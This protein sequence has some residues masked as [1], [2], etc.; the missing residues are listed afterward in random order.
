MPI[1]IN[2]GKIQLR[3]SD[4]YHDL[5]AIQGSPGY[6]VQEGGTAGQVLKKAS[7][8]DYD[9]E[10][11][12]E[13]MP[14]KVSDLDNDTGFITGMEI[15]SY[16][17]STYADF[18]AAYTAKKVV[19]CRASS[20]AN[21]ASG[22]QTRL[23][24]MAYVNDADNPTEVEFQYYRSV[25]AHTASQQGDQ[26]FVYK[27]TKTA[28]WTVT[29][30]EASSKIV[31]GTNM[32]SSYSNGVI[33]LNADTPTK[34]MVVTVTRSGHALS[35]DKTFSEIY[36]AYQNGRQIIA[37]LGSDPEIYTLLSVSSSLI[38]FS[39][40]GVNY[41]TTTGVAQ[42]TIRITSSNSVSML[43]GQ[44]LPPP[45]ISNDN[46]IIT[47]ELDETVNPPRYFVSSSDVSDVSQVTT[48]YNEKTLVTLNYLKDYF[49][50]APGD[51]HE[52]SFEQY[53][54]SDVQ[55][56]TTYDEDE[57]TYTMKF[58]LIFINEEVSSSGSK[59][60]KF[61]LVD[62]V[63]AYNSLQDATVTYSE[64]EIGGGGGA[65]YV[66]FTV[67]KNP[68]SCTADKTY[69]QVKAGLDNGEIYFALVKGSYYDSV[70][71]VWN[72]SSYT[73][74]SITFT[75]RIAGPTS[76]TGT[77]IKIQ[78]VHLLSDGIASTTGESQS[79][80]RPHDEYGYLY[81]ECNDDNQ[82]QDSP[83]GTFSISP[84]SEIYTMDSAYAAIGLSYAWDVRLVYGNIDS[85]SESKYEIYHLVE[86]NHEFVGEFS[87]Q[88]KYTLVFRTLSEKNGNPV[89]KKVIAVGVD[90]D[91]SGAIY[92]SGGNVT[93]TYSETALATAQ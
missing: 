7:S 11:T 40:V 19:Y 73:E 9:T 25:S 61:E 3:D 68:Y 5:P 67:N 91:Y 15:L 1:T 43:C 32:T 90:E 30:R 24:F 92:F 34:Q 59:I 33:T 84:S 50:G 75:R 78:S 35:A 87:D 29:T 13:I 89:I 88:N 71:S 46:P 63:F 26:V 45:E 17:N 23:A 38:V 69:Q 64:E 54:L 66:T 27:L 6:G 48:N 60:K 51:G 44:V 16:G 74:R 20:N 56:V 62:D 14:T 42:D 52:E 82:Y 39:Y 80:S 10:W 79:A 41:G 58:H 22:S 2:P 70:P 76:G 83:S 28:G 65:N 49:T 21:P 86:A 8:D 72:L 12:D 55:S 77:Q 93:V 47:V 36:S 37:I 57:G 85:Y 53:H 81:L 18:L 4:G 31:A